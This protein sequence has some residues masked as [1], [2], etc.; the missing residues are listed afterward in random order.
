MTRFRFVSDHADD[1]GVKRL[2]STLKVSRS[3]YYDWKR[4][5]PVTTCARE[6]A[7]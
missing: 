2:C 1:Y 6:M 5:P 3:G 4:R 7:S